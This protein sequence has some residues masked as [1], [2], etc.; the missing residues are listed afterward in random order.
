MAH[1]LS[2]F[3]E[4]CCKREDTVQSN[5]PSINNNSLPAS[6]RPSIRPLPRVDLSRYRVT[7]APLLRQTLEPPAYEDL[8][9]RNLIT[10][11]MDQQSLLPPP[12]YE[13]FMR[14]N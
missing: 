8:V 2:V 10:T 7:T 14:R 5:V 11:S 6:D 9:R 12:T 3:I 1:P 4:Q 13:E